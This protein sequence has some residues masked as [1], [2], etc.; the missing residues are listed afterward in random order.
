LRKGPTITAEQRWLHG[1]EPENVWGPWNVHVDFCNTEFLDWYID[2]TQAWLETFKPSGIAWDMGWDSHVSPCTANSEDAPVG[3]MVGGGAH[4]GAQHGLLRAM[5][6]V[7]LWAKEKHPEMHFLMNGSQNTPIMRYV[8]GVL[9]EG[10]WTAS[11]E[12]IDICKFYGTPITNLAYSGQYES[13]DAAREAAMRMMSYGVTHANLHLT[14]EEREMTDFYH[15]SALANSVPLVWED[16]AIAFEW[17]PDEI[18]ENRKAELLNMQREYPGPAPRHTPP[19]GR[20]VTGSVW[21]SSEHVLMAIY[22][23]KERDVP[24]RAK[25]SGKLLKR[26]GWMGKRAVKFTVLG[27]DGFPVEKNDFQADK[28][29]V[30]GTLGPGQLV[31]GIGARNN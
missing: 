29:R 21:A 17:T 15:F 31:L 11:K 10:G 18:V 5:A 9:F 22:N 8:S 24:V 6:D 28:F 1:V 14:S 16:E 3:R 13:L 26:Y 12:G 23:H 19:P 7:F 25:V 20:L 2:M 30:T 4:G 27:S